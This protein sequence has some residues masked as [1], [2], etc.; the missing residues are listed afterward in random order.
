MALSFLPDLLLAKQY[1][2]RLDP[3]AELCDARSHT[4][5]MHACTVQDIS[6]CLL[7]YHMCV[8]TVLTL[9]FHNISKS[10]PSIIHL[11]QG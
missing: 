4:H 8:L 7:R 10:K 2:Q 9:C 3:G 1:C 6:V 5:T 11:A